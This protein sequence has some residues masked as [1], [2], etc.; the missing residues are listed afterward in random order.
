MAK[1]K[2]KI[3][4]RPTKTGLDGVYKTSMSFADIERMNVIIQDNLKDVGEDGEEGNVPIANLKPLV[5]FFFAN[6]YCDE[7]GERFED[8]KTVEDLDD[9]PFDAIVGET[10]AIMEEIAASSSK[11]ST[12]PANS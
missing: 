10:V 3:K 5:L 7:H 8:V 12:A 2:S 6:V 11:K 1:L 9:L 4:S